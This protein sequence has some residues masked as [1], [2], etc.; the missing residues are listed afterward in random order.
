MGRKRGAALSR[1]DV[2]RAAIACLSEEGPGAL[3]I[4]RV[5]RALGIRPPSLYHHVASNEDL[6]RL[7]AIEGWRQ[8]GVDLAD[9]PGASDPGAS[10]VALATAFRRFV[11]DHPAWYQVMSETRLGQEDPEFHP[12]ASAIMQDFAQALAPYGLLG[13]EVVH[14]VRM[15]RAT[16]H[17]F[18]SLELSGQFGMPYNVD[19]SFQ[20][21]LAQ[22]TT[23]L[24][25]RSTSKLQGT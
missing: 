1:E 14:A 7:V 18:V 13:D 2:I 24:A 3:G 25:G 16:L 21:I 8:L 20:W 19:E 12:V 15:L 9:R 17:G 11:S 10:I 23:T 4:N 5:A 6:A 22:V